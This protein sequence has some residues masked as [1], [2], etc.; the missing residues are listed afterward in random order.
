M[1]T[2]SPSLTWM[3]AIAAVL[4]LTGCHSIPTS[5]TPYAGV[6]QFPPSKTAKVEILRIDPTRRHVRLGEIKVEPA[7]GVS[8]GEIETA[9]R[10]QAAKL[11]ADAALVVADRV[12]P[13]APYVGGWRSSAAE[14][15][16][17]R[18]VIAVAIKYQ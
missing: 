12:R 9:L 5:F 8:A 2:K 7:G 13:P 4:T 14:P 18:E 6:G 16:P 1:T 15:L 3:A 10:Q 11:G 17:Q